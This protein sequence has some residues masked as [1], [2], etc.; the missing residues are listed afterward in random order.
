VSA[1]RRRALPKLL[2]Q[3][4]AIALLTADGWTLA[5]GGKHVVKMRRQGHR[6][7]TLPSANG[8]RYSIGLTRAIYKQAGL[9][10][11]SEV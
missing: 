6:P 2:D 10:N 1:G 11:E 7:I 4:T 8:E 5:R 3:R 9:T